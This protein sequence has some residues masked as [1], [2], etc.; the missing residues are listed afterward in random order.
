MLKKITNSWN[1]GEQMAEF[2]REAE[3]MVAKYGWEGRTVMP[4]EHC[5]LKVTKIIEDCKD[6]HRCTRDSRDY[7]VELV[8]GLVP[9]MNV[10]EEHEKLPKIEV[11]IKKS[12]KVIKITEDWLEAL[13]DLVERI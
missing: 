3:A 12:G 11:R 10:W 6:Y 7:L 9:I 2:V 1:R 8:N 5:A 4:W 13:D